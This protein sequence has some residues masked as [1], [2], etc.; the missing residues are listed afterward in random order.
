MCSADPNTADDIVCCVSFPCICGVFIPLF[1]ICYPINFLCKQ[2][3]GDTESCNEVE[4]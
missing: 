1:I 2:T 3:C 4:I